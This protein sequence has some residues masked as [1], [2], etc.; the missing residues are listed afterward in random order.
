MYC[1]HCNY[2]G[3]SVYWPFYDLFA[4]CFQEQQAF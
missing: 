1:I 3:S 2:G 4:R